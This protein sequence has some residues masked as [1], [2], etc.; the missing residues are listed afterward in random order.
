MLDPKLTGKP[1]TRYGFQ[2]LL[3]GRQI[4]FA[5]PNNDAANATRLGALEFDIAAYDA[6]GKLIN[7]LSQSIKLPLTPDQA[8]QLAKTP[9]RFFQQLDLPS[10]QLFLRIGIL[11]RTSNKAGTL[12]IPLSVPKK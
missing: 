1:L 7:S 11:D 5:V 8:Q 12:E 10:G 4:A 3:P 9:F 2:Y 6:Q